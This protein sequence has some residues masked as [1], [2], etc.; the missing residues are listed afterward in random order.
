MLPSSDAPLLG[1]RALGFERTASTAGQVPVAMER[2]ALL[3][4]RH[5]VGKHLAG[6]TAVCVL[7]ADID[8]VLLA[9]R[10]SALAPEVS[11]RGTY[12]VAPACSQA[13]ISSP[14]KYPRSASTL[15]SSQPW[16]ASPGAS[17]S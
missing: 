13:S 14:E 3:D 17:C 1:R 4:R 11:G 5:M 2:E 8:E 10:P 12:G 15:R 9:D 7:V 16:R 6:G